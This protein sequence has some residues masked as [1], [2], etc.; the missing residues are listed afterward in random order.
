MQIHL[1]NN[2]NRSR[3]KVSYLCSKLHIGILLACLLRNQDPCGYRLSVEYV[4]PRSMGWS[5][6]RRLGLPRP[7]FPRLS[8][9]L[10]GARRL[11]DRRW[12][13][14][15]RSQGRSNEVGRILPWMESLQLRRLGILLQCNR[16]YSS[17][18]SQLSPRWCFQL[19]WPVV[20]RFF[21]EA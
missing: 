10:R 7:G 21:G 18:V 2:L 3:C 12:G 14:D 20:N 4:M 5:W 1:N 16:I 6:E 8:Y 19:I 13:T 11:E 9:R 17:T 15:M